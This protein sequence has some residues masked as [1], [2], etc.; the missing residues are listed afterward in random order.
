MGEISARQHVFRKPAR[1]TV[2]CLNDLWIPVLTEAMTNS[3]E[4]RNNAKAAAAVNIDWIVCMIAFM[5]LCWPETEYKM[6]CEMNYER[7]QSMKRC[8]RKRR[9]YL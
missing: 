6:N 8:I 9:N 5:T 2:H 7:N 4:E 1:V 3:M